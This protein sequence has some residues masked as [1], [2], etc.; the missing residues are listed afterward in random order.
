MKIRMAKLSEIEFDKNF[1]SA[2]EELTKRFHQKVQ[3]FFDDLGREFKGRPVDE[4][5]PILA[6]RWEETLGGSI[7]EPELTNYATGLSGG[8]PI[9]IELTK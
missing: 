5:K 8:T 6:R 9:K 3:T 7:T 4:V 2:I 1:N